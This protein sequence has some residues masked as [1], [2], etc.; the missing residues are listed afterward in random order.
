MPDPSKHTHHLSNPNDP[1]LETRGIRGASTLFAMIE[2][3]PLSSPVDTMHQA[4]KG[5]ACDLLKLLCETLS[6]V[7]EVDP[8][9]KDVSIPSEFTC[10]LRP[11]KRLVLFKVSDLKNFLLYFSPIVFAPFM[12]QHQWYLRDLSNIVYTLRSL[13]ESDHHADLCGVDL[14]GGNVRHLILLWRLQQ[15]N[16][17]QPIISWFDL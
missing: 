1:E 12:T 2:N 3:L 16:F 17:S 11:L 14:C 15:P 6:C 5:V 9:I 13:Y 8:W 7:P 10:A 4:L